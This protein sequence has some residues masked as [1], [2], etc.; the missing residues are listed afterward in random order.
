MLPM[1]MNDPTM[2]DKIIKS[3]FI[4]KFGETKKKLNEKEPR[5]SQVR[6]GLVKLSKRNMKTEKDY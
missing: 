6:R 5:E 4:D 3:I 1:C 2:P